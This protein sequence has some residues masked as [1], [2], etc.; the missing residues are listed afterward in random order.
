MFQSL[1]YMNEPINWPRG[2]FT[3]EEAVSLNPAFP[4]QLVRK[5]LSEA[6]AA[7]AIVQTQKGDRRIKGKFQVVT[8][9]VPAGT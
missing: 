1:F 4:E 5:K 3:I 2:E 6:M 7:K 9:A 8:P